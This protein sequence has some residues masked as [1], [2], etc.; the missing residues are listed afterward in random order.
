MGA[1]FSG[2]MSA[3]DENA[4]GRPVNPPDRNPI[5]RMRNSASPGHGFK[6]FD[7]VGW[8]YL[9]PGVKAEMFT[10]TAEKLYALAQ[11]AFVAGDNTKA[12]FAARWLHVHQ[13]DAELAPEARRIVA[14]VYEKRGFHE[15]AFQEYQALLDAHPNYDA[16]KRAEVAKR[17]FDIAGSYLDGQWFRWKI[18]YQ[19]RMYLPVFSSMSRTAKLYKQVVANAP[20][21][22]MAASAQYGVGQAHE[23]ALTGFWGFFADE[24]AYQKATEAYQL[25][26]DRYQKR[27]GD[28][29]RP[30][31][32]EID[33]VVGEAGFR[34][35]AIFEVQA[36]EGVYDQSMAERAINAFKDFR[37]LNAGNPT[38]KPKLDEATDRING[39]H[40]ERVRG[41]LAI[42]DFYER[43]GKWIAAFKYFGETSFRAENVE[44]LAAKGTPIYEEAQRINQQA[45]T[46]LFRVSEKSVNEALDKAA[47]IENVDPTKLMNLSDR[48]LNSVERSSRQIELN[49]RLQ[50]DVLRKAVNGDDA[51]YQKVDALKGRADTLLKAAEAELD[52]REAEANKE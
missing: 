49:L 13:P 9:P 27:P 42:A 11:E 39:L 21:G 3:K 38:L 52:R 40:L 44:G 22:E 47:E 4:G 41:A 37:V 51:A 23:R 5:E 15:N 7:G 46:S 31:Q 25:L 8:K 28:A 50:E 1:V 48:E 26:A 6:Y 16:A 12:L 36:N 2:C 14:E 24:K 33:R 29:P 35:A 32:A 19:E 43:R 18:P 30:N 34:V 10:M 17:M 45:I 20:Y